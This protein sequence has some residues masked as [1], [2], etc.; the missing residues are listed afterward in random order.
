VRGFLKISLLKT[1]MKER[2]RE[3]EREKNEERETE[4]KRERER[5]PRRQNKTVSLSRLAS[6]LWFRNAGGNRAKE[7]TQICVV[8]RPHII[9]CIGLFLAVRPRYFI[10]KT[11]HQKDTQKRPRDIAIN[12]QKKQASHQIFCTHPYRC[13][14]WALSR[15]AST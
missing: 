8:A 9:A 13:L 5:T 4:R 12:L 14:F 10:K 3:R 7:H 11:L 15:G 2:A 6:F 1:L